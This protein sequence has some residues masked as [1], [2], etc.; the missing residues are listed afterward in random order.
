MTYFQHYQLEK[1]ALEKRSSLLRR[2]V[3]DK[4]ETSYDDDDTEMIDHKQGQML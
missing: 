4:E 1:I 2:N 3:S